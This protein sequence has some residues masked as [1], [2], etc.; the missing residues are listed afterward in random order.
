MENEDKTGKEA[1]TFLCEPGQPPL[2]FRALVSSS[3]QGEQKY[4]NRDV[5]KKAPA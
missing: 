4:H 1:L 5:L 3:V 2:P